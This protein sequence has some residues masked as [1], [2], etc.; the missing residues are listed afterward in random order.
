[1][2]VLDSKITL[3]LALRCNQNNFAHPATR[4]Y[5]V[6]ETAAAYLASEGSFSPV[7]WFIQRR[8]TNF[9]PIKALNNTTST[10]AFQWRLWI[11]L[12]TSPN[13][14]LLGRKNVQY[15][16]WI[17]TFRRGTMPRFSYSR[18]L[19]WECGQN[20]VCSPVNNY[21]NNRTEG[22]TFLRN[23]DFRWQGHKVSKPTRP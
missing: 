10:N 2:I 18:L 20:V 16:R 15:C 8:F 14:G 19:R 22:S 21:C 7:L 6:W 3:R 11:N 1:M 5:T 13:F 9:M 17:P 23:V 4:I 12:R